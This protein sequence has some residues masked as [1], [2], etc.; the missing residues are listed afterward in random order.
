MVTGWTAGRALSILVNL[1]Q[2]VGLFGAPSVS[3]SSISFLPA[4]GSRRRYSLK[5]RDGAPS[6]CNSAFTDRPFSSRSSLNL[7]KEG[8]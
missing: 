7:A 1:S 2:I 6:F 3:Q 5:L 8:G 4:F